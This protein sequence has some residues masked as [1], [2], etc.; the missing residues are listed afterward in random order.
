M[1]RH[2]P[3]T[4]AVAQSA[5]ER[6]RPE[7]AILF[8]SRARGD[9][10]ELKSD[11]DIMLVIKDQPGETGKE[12]AA[13]A[14][15]TTARKVYGREVPVQ[16]VWRTTQDFRHNRRYANSVETTAVREGIIMPRNPE[17]Y[18]PA[19]YEDENTEYEYNWTNYDERL[20][21]AEEHLDTFQTLDDLGKSDL[22]IAQ[23]AHSALEHG[24][25][26]LIAAHGG[27]YRNSHNLEHLLGTVKRI[28]QEMTDFSLSIPPDVYSEYA[29]NN[30]YN[31][32]GINPLPTEYPNYRDRTVNDVRRIMNR[33]RDVRQKQNTDET[34]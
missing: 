6:E 11:I 5:K 20:R 32:T 13:A 31:I 27:S 28:D 30:E 10:D 29:G 19:D 2:D 9:H 34:K 1:N 3:K 8:G 21:H 23:R 22:M 7:L 17:N 4:L 26:A 14:A 15:Q 25:K 18:N 24:M 16:L 33:T 12:S